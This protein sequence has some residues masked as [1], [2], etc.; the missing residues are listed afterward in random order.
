VA[1]ALE[2]V[3]K[4]GES[5]EEAA[6]KA[7]VSASTVH[8]HRAAQRSAGA[9]P[10][11]ASSLPQGGSATSTRPDLLELLRRIGQARQARAWA[12]I[13]EGL[14]VHQRGGEEALTEWLERPIA[15]AELTGDE[16]DTLREGLG[17]ALGVA[18]TAEAGGPQLRALGIVDRL[19]KSI[20]VVKSR[21]APEPSV[22]EV[23]RRILAARDL[24]L[25]RI[26]ILTSDT[27]ARFAAKRADFNAWCA[28][29]GTFG[30]EIKGR[31]DAMLA[32]GA[33]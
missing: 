25:D 7:G 5:I 8:A 16:L 29:L 22:D 31:V 2:I 33:A 20:S 17:F 21:R 32:G 6:K 12:E 28:S 3:A 27:A 1:K 19:G 30:A 26:G 14:V 13:E 15:A 18:R 9:K 11:A 23:T 10:T 24:A 4:T